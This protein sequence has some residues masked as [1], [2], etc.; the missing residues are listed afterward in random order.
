MKEEECNGYEARIDKEQQRKVA[1]I[2][3]TNIK[4]GL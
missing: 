1:I 4:V 2:A 3:L